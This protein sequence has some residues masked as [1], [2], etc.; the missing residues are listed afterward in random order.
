M[1]ILAECPICHQK[2]SIKNKRCSCGLELD[3]A[4]KVK[5]LRYWISYRMPDG[6]QRRKSVGAFEGLNPYS[7]KDA[8]NA[9]A[10]RVV[11]K[12]Q[13][14]IFEMLPESEMT[15]SELTEWFLPIEKNKVQSDKISDAY[16]SVKKINLE[17][18]NSVF[19]NMLVNR[20][21]PADLER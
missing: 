13:K 5:R 11:Q 8:R 10:K 15:F 4:K 2:Q 20:I 12:R 7:I 9:E 3:N 19:G 16:Y 1:G 21:E 18:F 6:K 14:R 17:I